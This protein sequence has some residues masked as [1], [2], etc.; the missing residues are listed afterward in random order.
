MSRKA[1]LHGREVI[2]MEIAGVDTSDAPDFVDTYIESAIWGH[3]GCLLD[4]DEL[5]ELNEN[6]DLIHGLIEDKLY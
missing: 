4:E 3:S 2:D 5:Q 1:E 6:Q